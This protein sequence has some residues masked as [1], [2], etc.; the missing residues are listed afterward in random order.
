M[1]EV[2]ERVQHAEAGRP[3]ETALADHLAY[4]VHV[5]DD[6]FPPRTYISI[7]SV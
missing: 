1:Q 4:R 2:A 6:E 7:L 5:E 3:G